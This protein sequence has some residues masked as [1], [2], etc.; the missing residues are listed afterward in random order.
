MYGY[1]IFIYENTFI[2]SLVSGYFLVGFFFTL[3]VNIGSMMVGKICIVKE[4]LV[5][6]E[7]EGFE[8]SGKTLL[9]VK[10][11]YELIYT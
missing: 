4:K 2:H 5:S 9:N 1:A 10:P 11:Q 7:P 6:K 8:V 3:G